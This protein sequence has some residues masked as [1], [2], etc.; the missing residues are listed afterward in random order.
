M[1]NDSFTVHNRGVVFHLSVLGIP[2]L[3]TACGTF[4]L[5][6]NIYP[7]AG[8]SKDQQE[9]D[10]LVCKDQ[11]K[12]A[13]NTAGRQTGAFFLG[14]TIVGAPVAFELEK[15]KQREVFAQ[16][17]TA[18]G[19]TVLSPEDGPGQAV[20]YTQP[21]NQPD[22]NTATRSAASPPTSNLSLTLPPG[23]TRLPLTPQ[24]S[25]GAVLY[26]TNRT[27]D[28]G[29]FLA[30]STRDGITD[31]AAFANARKANLANG[32]TDLQQSDT[33]QL[34]VNGKKAFRFTIAGAVKSGVKITYLMTIVEGGTE[35]A[36]LNAWTTTANFENQRA[37][38]ELLATNVTGL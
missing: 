26:A 9:T 25:S 18:R 17:L 1:K 35:I 6:S 13:A 5:A 22:A 37:A 24:M 19:Y 15:S 10:I 33:L 27:I 21:T 16:C 23:W 2:L 20:A 12:L 34:E 38:I 31:L 7:P 32:L 36:V 3:C 4:Q 11:A 14:M 28:A 30:T 8:K 29:A